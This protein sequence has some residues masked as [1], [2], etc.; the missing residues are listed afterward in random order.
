MVNS[1]RIY[2]MLELIY[3]KSV[4]ERKQSRLPLFKQYFVCMKLVGLDTGFALLDQR[5]I[6]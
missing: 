6:I 5:N 4:V 1:R 3:I 2:N